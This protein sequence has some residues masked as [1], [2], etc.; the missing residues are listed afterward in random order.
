MGQGVLGFKLGAHLPQVWGG[1]KV[2]LQGIG[3]SARWDEELGFEALE[4]CEL[5]FTGH[6]VPILENGSALL[7][8]DSSE[9]TKEAKQV[10]VGIEIV[11][12]LEDVGLVGFHG[13]GALG[14]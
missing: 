7:M 14:S 2:V 9:G 10:V 4:F 13:V 1:I 6:E 8:R 5:V 3:G 11:V 12:E